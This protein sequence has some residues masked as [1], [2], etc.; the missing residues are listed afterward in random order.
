MIKIGRKYRIF[1][2]IELLV[3][4]SIIAI[5]AA[6]LLPALNS[7]RE[8]AKSTACLNNLKQ[9]AL[10]I[11]FYA[12]DNDGYMPAGYTPYEIHT[13]R[14]PMAY[15]VY[16]NRSS[17]DPTAM[18]F[19]YK[20]RSNFYCPSVERETG[21]TYASNTMDQNEIENTRVPFSDYT[22]T[23]PL[24]KYARILPHV[25]TIGDGH[26]RY[27]GINPRR[28]TP[29]YDF[30]C[31]GIN[32]SYSSDPDIKF[33]GFAADRHA[34]SGNYT[35]GDGSAASKAFSEFEDNLY[36]SGWLADTRY[37]TPLAW[38]LP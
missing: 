36:H 34:G 19:G 4:I 17:D 14:W 20:G 3:V 26:D 38:S 21:W 16:L 12:D 27:Y 2:L 9:L 32:D 22:T 30:S 25:M 11:P 6:L 24:Q 33:Y 31:N 8:K 15:G 18:N 35:F 23:K 13:M 7:A 10:V 37:D 28:V 5:L 1:T 29:M